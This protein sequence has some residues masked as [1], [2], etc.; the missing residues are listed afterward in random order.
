[1][2]LTQYKKKTNIIAS[3][4]KFTTV[5]VQTIQWFQYSKTKEKKISWIICHQW[6]HQSQHTLKKIPKLIRFKFCSI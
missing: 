5:F 3:Y 1:M 4:Y 6:R 2:S